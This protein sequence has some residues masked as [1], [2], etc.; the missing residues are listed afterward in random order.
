MPYAWNLLSLP[1][2][3]VNKYYKYV[4][5]NAMNIPL[6]F[7][8]SGW[9]QANNGELKRG[10]AYFI[11]YNAITDTTFHGASFNVIAN[12]LGDDIPL[13]SGNS[14]ELG[15]WNAVGGVSK[16]TS[17]NNILFDFFNGTSGDKDYTLFHGVWAYRPNQGYVEISAL[18]PGKGYFLKVNRNSYYRLV[19]TTKSVF[20]ELPAN[21]KN[22]VAGFDKINVADAN[23]KVATLYA[24]NNID[25]NNYQLPPLPPEELF[26]VRFSKDNYATNYDESLV[27]MQGITYPV[28]VN[29]TNPRANYSVIDPVSG[30]VYGTIKAGET[31]NI[32]INYSKTNSFRLVAETS[33]ETFFV[34]VN[35]NPVVT[36]I[37]EVS[38]GIDNDANV[39]LS[40]FNTLGLEV[41]NIN[42]YVNKGIYNRTFDVT[43][44]PAGAY[45]VRLLANGEVRIF[46]MNIVK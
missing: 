8:N 14:P 30:D 16:I 39:S 34:A 7:F 24:A 5:P 15:G 21:L 1:L 6:Y 22:K 44:L 42:E 13:Y 3:P 20:D 43:N 23:Q 29:F 11:K 41:A 45:T 17:I 46:M 2:D 26:D 12:T 35:Q 40:I 4:Y 9:Q 18:Y 10:M 27:N 25:V 36:N 37:A 32:V 28:L 33:N 19:N 38:F 31:N